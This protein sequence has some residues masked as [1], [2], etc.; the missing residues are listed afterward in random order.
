M[1][2]NISLKHKTLAGLIFLLC[3][4]KFATLPLVGVLST[5]RSNDIVAVTASASSYGANAVKCVGFFDGMAMLP[6]KAD[7][8]RSLNTGGSGSAMRCIETQTGSVSF[9]QLT[10][11]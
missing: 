7:C 2:Q 10:N 6:L 3:A 11:V 4:G 5:F 9:N 8:V 1:K